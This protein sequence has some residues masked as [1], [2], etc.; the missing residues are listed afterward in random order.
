MVTVFGGTGF[1]GRA[2]VRQLSGAGFCVRV[3]ARRPHRFETAEAD[4]SIEHMAADI[5]DDAAVAAAVN[6]AIAVI[7]AVG[8]YV[9]HRDLTFEAVHVEGAARIAR[10]TKAA[11]AARIVH[12]SGIG[13]TPDSPSRYIA[14]RGRGE[15]AVRTVAPD[16]TILRPSV[17]Y[18]PGDAFIN[19]LVALTR[20]PVIPLFG[21]GSTRLQPVHVDDVAAAVAC[22]LKDG[23]GKRRTLELG[24]VE[25]LSYRAII[26]AVM[27]ATG[28]HRPMLPIPF[29]LWHLLAAVTGVL[30]GAL[31]TRDQVILMR[32]DN[33]AATG[34]PGFID[35][36]IAPQSLISYLQ[37]AVPDH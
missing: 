23:N 7:N 16:S 5:R 28:R 32:T 34:A 15:T 20:L 10:L 33:I 26:E 37:A 21:D 4:G 17:L 35:L 30:P 27:A 1:L 25:V 2:I 14:A 11:G 8:L 31:L 9:E 13:A 36:G 12:V 3:A 19:T 18:G 22:V 24:G 29:P 6:G